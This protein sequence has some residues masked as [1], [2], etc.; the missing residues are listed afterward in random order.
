MTE[1]EEGKRIKARELK[2]AVKRL[3]F[4]RAISQKNIPRD[5]LAHD[6]IKEIKES[7]EIPPA[8]ETAKRYISKARNMDSPLEE[9]WTIGCCAQYS[10]YFT[11][12]SIT[13][14]MEYKKYFKS[15]AENTPEEDEIMKTTGF[16]SWDF[17]IRHCIW[18][19]RLKPV[20]EKIFGELIATREDIRMGYPVMIAWTYALAEFSSEVMGEDKF[21][22]LDLDNALFSGD[23]KTMAKKSGE[24]LLKSAKKR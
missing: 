21:D 7:G 2:P 10:Q 6:L 18:I 15:I 17:S 9:I 11:P 13:L 5:F 12:D 14:L 20:I 8:L 19:I 24:F 22:S 4:S 3:I 23:L 1:D 16:S